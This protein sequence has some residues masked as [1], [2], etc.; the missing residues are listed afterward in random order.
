MCGRFSLTVSPEAIAQ[1]FNL[2][3]V[4]DSQPRYNIAPSQNIATLVKSKEIPEKQFQWM[5]WGLVPS[6]AKDIKIGYKLINARVETVTEKPSFRSAIKQRRCLI[7]ADGFYEWQKQ[8]KQKQPYYFQLESGD[9]F[10]FAGLW[11]TWNSPE[12]ERVISCTILT[13]A[14][15][16]VVS[17]IH[18]RMPIIVPSQHYQAW[19]DPEITTPQDILPLLSEGDRDRLQAKPAS[20]MVN[21]PKYDSPALALSA[22]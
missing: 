9:V 22:E 15:D 4:P 7:L 6:W 8:G 14:A 5:R 19:L 17:P 12:D 16:A 2:S 20:T 13:T 18:E 11:E 21:N 10:A 3:Q 1:Q